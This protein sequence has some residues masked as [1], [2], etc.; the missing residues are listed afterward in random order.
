MSQSNIKKK[1]KFILAHIEN[2]LDNIIEQ[3]ELHIEAGDKSYCHTLMVVLNAKCSGEKDYEIVSCPEV[4][5]GAV[6]VKNE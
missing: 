5:I 1:K 4:V 2:A 3:H 6:P